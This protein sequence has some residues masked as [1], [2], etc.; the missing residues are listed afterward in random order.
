MKR[1][2]FIAAI[3]VMVVAVVSCE[4]TIVHEGIIMDIPF[5]EFKEESVAVEPEGGEMVIPVTSTG[6]DNVVIDFQPA[7]NWEMDPESGDMTPKDGWIKLVKV[8]D[9][10]DD[11]T[12]ALPT[13]DSG[14][15]IVVEPN[16]TGYERRAWITVQ[17]FTKSD[18]IVVVQYAGSFGPEE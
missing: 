12:R 10:Y 1:I 8:I 17:S 7:D 18:T 2:K 6:V 14:I 16:H 3:A 15:S 13:W 5:V 4:R 11:S 9:Q